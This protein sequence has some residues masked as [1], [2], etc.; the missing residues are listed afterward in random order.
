MGDK[1]TQEGITVTSIGSNIYIVREGADLHLSVTIRI[2][3]EDDSVAMADAVAMQ[4]I[5]TN[6]I[7]DFVKDYAADGQEV[8]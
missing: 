3:D 6:L 2:N 4:D 1:F 7:T 8:G 5:L